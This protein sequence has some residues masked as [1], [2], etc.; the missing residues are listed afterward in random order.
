MILDLNLPDISGLEVITRLQRLNLPPRI[1]VV[2]A[3]TH[4]EFSL[5]VFEAGGLGYLSKTA[6]QDEWIAAIK[7]VSKGQPYLSAEIANRLALAKI[8][9]DTNRC[10]QQI[11]S[12]GNGSPALHAERIIH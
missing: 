4:P 1:L 5:Q 11:K 9:L 10:I 12:Q 7:T 8:N 3:A 2:T 6:D